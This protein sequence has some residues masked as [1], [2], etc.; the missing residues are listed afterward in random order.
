MV[1]HSHK[2]LASEENSTTMLFWPVC[3]FW[4]HVMSQITSE[5]CFHL[6]DVGVNIWSVFV[7]GIVDRH[8]ISGFKCG[9][10]IESGICV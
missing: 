5:I 1:K 9:S 6:G 8:F 2:I 4:S 10:L 3:V 7:F